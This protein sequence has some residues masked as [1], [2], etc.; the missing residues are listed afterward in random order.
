MIEDIRDTLPR[1]RNPVKAI[2]AKCLECCAGNKKEV[3]ACETVKCLLHEWRFGKNPYR[4]EKTQEQREAAAERL[5]K[6]RN[7]NDKTS[8]AQE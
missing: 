3:K 5:K 2:K 1:F 6:W 7:K 4:K 8:A